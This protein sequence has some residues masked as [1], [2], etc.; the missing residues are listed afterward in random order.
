[1]LA[2]IQASRLRKLKKLS[3][4]FLFLKA[5][6]MQSTVELWD[7]TRVVTSKTSTKQLQATGR[8]GR[9]MKN[10]SKAHVREK[11]LE[12]KVKRVYFSEGYQILWRPWEGRVLVLTGS[13]RS[14][15]I[16]RWD[17]QGKSC[18]R[19]TAEVSLFHDI[20][21]YNSFPTIYWGLLA[22]SSATVLKC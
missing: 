10:R 8:V 17:I 11:C 2:A 6:K 19:I 20:F 1:M 21:S 15:T 4:V 18:G 16:L 14:G 7:Q 13:K 12:A 22:F 9:Q 5:K 3:D